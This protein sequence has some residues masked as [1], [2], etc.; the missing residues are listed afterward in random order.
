M[1][2]N[3]TMT[4]THHA[5]NHNRNHHAA[6]TP[7]RCPSDGLRSWVWPS[8][9]GH[10]RGHPGTRR[11]Q[12]G[13]TA[14]QS[15]PGMHKTVCSLKHSELP[16]RAGS[17]VT[18]LSASHARPEPHFETDGSVCATRSHR[19]ACTRV[20]FAPY[21]RTLLG[22]N[23]PQWRCGRFTCNHCHC[24]HLAVLNPHGQVRDARCA[25]GGTLHLLCHA[26]VRPPRES[27]TP[28]EED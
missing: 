8:S 14:C 11:P 27:H 4:G 9:W 28:A 17:R 5:T 20:Q 7:S 26:E 22:T 15:R 21:F 16:H 6:C 10:P 12:P 1:T 2:H 13:G 18:A 23:T 24:G 19:C 3:D 25:I